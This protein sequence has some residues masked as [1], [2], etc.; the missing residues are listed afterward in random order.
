M[1]THIVDY[2]EH[3]ETLKYIILTGNIYFK[4]NNYNNNKNTEKKKKKGGGF[5]YVYLL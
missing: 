4:Q 5:L 2:I 1:V 3:F